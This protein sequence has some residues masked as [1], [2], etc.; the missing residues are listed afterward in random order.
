[1]TYIRKLMKRKGFT[2]IELLVVIAI[3]AV[4]AG[5]LLPAISNARERAN[6]ISCVNN[7]KQF[8][9]GLYLYEDSYGENNWPSGPGPTND[10]RALGKY[11]NAPKMYICKSDKYRS[12]APKIEDITG[13]NCSYIYLAGYQASDNGNFVVMF[14][15]NG[16]EEPSGILA[17]DAKLLGAT[18][19]PSQ[20]NS[21][22]GNH[23]TEGGNA[24]HV[25]G[26][27][28]WIPVVSDDFNISDLLNEMRFPSN[29]VYELTVT[30]CA[31]VIPAK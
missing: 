21:W 14:D 1:M 5:L 7:L 3:I 10:I 8:G 18:T 11:A 12:A 28:E 17:E 4:L 23:G 19:P 31:E 25:D 2:L 26:H 22:G 9:T 30:T 6:R 20:A 15:K 24:L 29:A 27:A 16:R 13:A